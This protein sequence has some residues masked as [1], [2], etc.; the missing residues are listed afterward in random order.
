MT[1]PFFPEAD[2]AP[3]PVRSVRKLLPANKEDEVDTVNRSKFIL[4]P[5]FHIYA[6]LRLFFSRRCYIF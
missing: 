1:A 4:V 6:Q 2:I 5:V 3:Q